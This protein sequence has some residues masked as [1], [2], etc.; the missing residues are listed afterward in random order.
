MT[1]R[2]RSERVVAA[3]DGASSGG[4]GVRAQE[5]EGVAGQ[6][7]GRLVKTEAITAGCL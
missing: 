4:G 2:E 7:D 5:V 3:S 1:V 6:E